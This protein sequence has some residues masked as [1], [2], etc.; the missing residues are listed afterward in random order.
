VAQANLVLDC[1]VE[2]GAFAF[3]AVACE[4]EGQESAARGAFVVAV[5]GGGERGGWRGLG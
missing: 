4:G 3:L 2:V 1:V 5:V